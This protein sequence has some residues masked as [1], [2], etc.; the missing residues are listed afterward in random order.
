MDK[1]NLSGLTTD[2]LKQKIKFQ[3]I[4]MIF[5]LI[6]MVIMLFAGLFIMYR[7]RKFTPFIVLPIAFL[8]IFVMT[9]N[10][11]KKYIAEL[12]SREDNK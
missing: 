4:S 10:S 8:P 5:F 2:E 3:T 1:D 7:T 6:S 11:R 9:V 12:H